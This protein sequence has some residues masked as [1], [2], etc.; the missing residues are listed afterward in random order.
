[1]K[2]YTDYTFYN[3]DLCVSKRLTGNVMFYVTVPRASCFRGSI[4]D[5]MG[6]IRHR[7]DLGRSLRMQRGPLL[8]IGSS[9]AAAPRWDW[10]FRSH[11]LSNQTAV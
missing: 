9:A 8:V 4:I 1:M 6:S 3:N 2:Y 10:S 7:Q 11:F 5:C